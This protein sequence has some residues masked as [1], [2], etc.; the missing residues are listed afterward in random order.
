MNSLLLVF[1]LMPQIDNSSWSSLWLSAITILKKK[2]KSYLE[3]N[4]LFMSITQV[5]D[6]YCQWF[7]KDTFYWMCQN[8]YVHPCFV[9]VQAFIYLCHTFQKVFANADGCANVWSNKKWALVPH[10]CFSQA[11]VGDSNPSRVFGRPS[12]INALCFTALWNV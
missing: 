12:G 11:G 7:P 3:N 5:T 4:I 2:K 10:W 8:W 6:L 9:P 1:Q